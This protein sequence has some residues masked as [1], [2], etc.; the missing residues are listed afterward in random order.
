MEAT[1][2]T[3][4]RESLGGA[5]HQTSQQQHSQVTQ[6]APTNRPVPPDALA[7]SLYGK[8]RAEGL[9]ETDMMALV[10]ELMGLVTAEMRGKSSEG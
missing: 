7:R 10:G 9:T 4:S 5:V 3:P 6:V 1:S 2:H 8:L